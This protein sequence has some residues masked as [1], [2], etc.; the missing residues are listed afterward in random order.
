MFNLHLRGLGAPGSSEQILVFFIMGFLIGAA[1][2]LREQAFAWF[3]LTGGSLF[4]LKWVWALPRSIWTAPMATTVVL[5][6]VG[7][8]AG[9]G[10]MLYKSIVTLT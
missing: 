6:V 7:L 5:G 10:F 2:V 9:S 4:G 8:A 3:A 1:V